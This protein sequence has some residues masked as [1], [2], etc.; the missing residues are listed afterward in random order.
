MQ[1]E[2]YSG[3]LAI[4]QH[5][6]AHIKGRRLAVDYDPNEEEAEAAQGAQAE[7]GFDRT[8][9]SGGGLCIYINSSWC[10]NM[11]TVASR[12]S[13]VLEYL[14]VKCRPFYIPLEFTGVTLTVVANVTSALEM[15]N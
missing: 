12:C 13:P 1:D 6:G 3:V 2:Y 7:D 4:T 14:T 15:H 9:D 11:E 10:S 8:S 5:S